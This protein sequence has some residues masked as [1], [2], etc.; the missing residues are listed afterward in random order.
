MTTFG[1]SLSEPVQIAG[2][3]FTRETIQ[4]TFTNGVFAVYH[5]HFLFSAKSADHNGALPAEDEE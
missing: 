2:V 5:A 3:D 1:I 4:V